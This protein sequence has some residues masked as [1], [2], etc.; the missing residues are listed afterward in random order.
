MCVFLPFPSPSKI[1]K[2][3]K[4]TDC[5]CPWAKETRRNQGPGWTELSCVCLS[6]LAVQNIRS[7]V[8]QAQTGSHMTTQPEWQPA[9]ERKQPSHHSIYTKSYNQNE[10]RGGLG[11][12]SVGLILNSYVL[13]YYYILI[14]I[15]KPTKSKVS[16]AYEI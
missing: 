11:V 10:G 12:G 15:L 2:S 5:V 8:Q 1:T 9:I 3:G 7:P 14:R 4:Q 13:F 6:T 16:G